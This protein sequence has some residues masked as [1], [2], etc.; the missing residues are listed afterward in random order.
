MVFIKWKFRCNSELF[1]WKTIY[2]Y[3][4]CSNFTPK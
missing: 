2:I 1:N 3:G 4:T